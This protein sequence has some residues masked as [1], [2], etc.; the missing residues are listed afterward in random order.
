MNTPT[1]TTEEKHL[2]QLLETLEK[3]LKERGKCFGKYDD[4]KQKLYEY[5]CLAVKFA[6][7]TRV[8]KRMKIKIET[9]I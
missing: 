2:L 8:F 9:G 6:D 3:Q 7:I 4:K 5:S 1:P